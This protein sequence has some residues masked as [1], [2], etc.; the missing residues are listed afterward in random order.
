MV[1]RLTLLLLVIS[2]SLGCRLSAASPTNE[3]RERFARVR[4]NTSTGDQASVPLDKR[5]TIVNLFDEF[6]TECPSGS[7][8]ETMERLHSL[9]PAKSILLIFSDKHFSNQDLENFK[10]ILPLPDSI[11]QGDIEAIR[12]HLTAGK[13]LV[14]LDS[15]GNV[16]WH[17]KPNMSEQQVLSEVSALKD[18]VGE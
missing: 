18:S 8:F 15:K 9:Q 7:R 1:I 3:F 2:F 6:S 16:V 5:L 14:V 12:T 11:V 4:I 10:A 13:L 17:E